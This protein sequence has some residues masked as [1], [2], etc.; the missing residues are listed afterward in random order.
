MDRVSRNDAGVL[1]DDDLADGRDA[2]ALELTDD[3]VGDLVADGVEPLVLARL[4]G[5]EAGEVAP[6]VDEVELGV[7][8]TLL[9]SLGLVVEAVDADLD[10][11]DVGVG[12][13]RGRGHE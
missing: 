1:R 12:L 10:V 2:L 4:V 5:L 3:G 11:L 8:Q 6:Q 9:G 13:R 7:V